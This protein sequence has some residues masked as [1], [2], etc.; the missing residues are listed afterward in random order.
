MILLA[1]WT[2]IICIQAQTKIS[3]CTLILL[4]HYLAETNGSVCN[5][6]TPWLVLYKLSTNSQN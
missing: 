4:L 5:C 1:L 6:R 2:E 3:H